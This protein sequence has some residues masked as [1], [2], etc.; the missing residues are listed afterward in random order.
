MRK[1]NFDFKDYLD[2]MVNIFL[3]NHYFLPKIYAEYSK[4]K[5]ELK[6]K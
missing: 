1:K 6:E 5:L 3:I 2:F 4:L